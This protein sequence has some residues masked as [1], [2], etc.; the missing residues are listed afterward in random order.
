MQQ[1]IGIQDGIVVGVDKFSEI[2]LGQFRS[3][4][5]RG[6][7]A[8]F[9]RIEVVIYRPVT[10]AGVEDHENLLFVR[11]LYFFRKPFMQNSVISLIR[12]RLPLFQ[13][14]DHHVCSILCYNLLRAPEW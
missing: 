14:T 2:R 7:P 9:L 6:E 3:R 1:E 4:A 10:R 13:I 11:C 5:D 8:E 12:F